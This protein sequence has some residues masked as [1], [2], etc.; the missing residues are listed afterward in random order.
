MG[1]DFILGEKKHIEMEIK[2]TR[3]QK[4]LIIDANYILYNENNEEVLTGICE[5]E[6]EHFIKILLE[7]TSRGKYTLEVTYTIPPEIRKARC[8]VNV[9]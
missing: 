1:I 5:I 7:P 8:K 3:P 4:I 9:Y 6:D 2:S